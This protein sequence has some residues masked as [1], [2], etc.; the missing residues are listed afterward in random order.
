MI[1]SSLFCVENV[2]RELLLLGARSAP[3]VALLFK[4]LVSELVAW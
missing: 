4:P 1:L 3:G 2:A